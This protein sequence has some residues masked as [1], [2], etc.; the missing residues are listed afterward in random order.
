MALSSDSTWAN[1]VTKDL[2]SL[3]PIDAIVKASSVLYRGSFCTHDSTTGEIKPYDGSV[4]DRA[5][6][7][8]FADSV[9]GNSSA[10][11]NKG[12]ILKGGFQALIPVTGLHGT[13]LSTDYGKPVYISDDG[14]YTLSGTT[15]TMRVGRVVPNDT[16]VTVGTNA[17]VAMRDMFG[18]VG[19]E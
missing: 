9:T 19:G 16:H 8:H 2:D 4:A 7:W 18:R 1:R 14:T 15:S 13:T 6:G 10:P 12:R 11:R 17:W 5:V 3:K